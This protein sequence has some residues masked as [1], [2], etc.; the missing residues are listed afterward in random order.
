MEKIKTLAEFKTLLLNRQNTQQ[1][2]IVKVGAKWCN[3]CKPVSAYLQSATKQPKLAKIV[4]FY[5]VD[6]DETTDI[7]LELKRSKYKNIPMVLFYHF[8]TPVLENPNIIPDKCFIG[9]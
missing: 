5:E 6:I 2:I 3:P 1:H 9:S 4:K 8:A 7:Y